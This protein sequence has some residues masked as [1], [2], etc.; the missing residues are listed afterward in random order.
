MFML[1]LEQNIKYHK[2]HLAIEQIHEL[3]D[4]QFDLDSFKD[5]AGNSLLHLAV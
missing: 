1:E 2:N 5:Y 4:K 3:A